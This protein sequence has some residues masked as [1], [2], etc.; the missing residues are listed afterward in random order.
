VVEGTAC[1]PV[2][3]QEALTQCQQRLGQEG[4][5]F[6]AASIKPSRPVG[7]DDLE[8][9]V[10][11]PVMVAGQVRGVSFKRRGEVVPLLMSCEMALAVSKMASVL[12]EI[13]ISE[14]THLGVY[15]CRATR[16]GKRL[17]QHGLGTAMDIVSFKT[18]SGQRLSVSKDW[19]RGVTDPRTK[20][21]RLLLD[22]ARRLHRGYVFNIIL[23]PEYNEDHH[24]HLHVDLTPDRHFLSVGKQNVTPM[25][26]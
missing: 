4:V 17:S 1:L 11:D 15:N 20:S 18:E 7:R 23:T 26:D 2:G 25:G 21:G 10:I 19:E 13:Q 9:E 3:D 6:R 5:I 12:A 24:D 22:I 14:V 16:S 8:C